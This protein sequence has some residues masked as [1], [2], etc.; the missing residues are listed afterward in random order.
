MAYKPEQ[1]RLARLAAFWALALLV[2]YGAAS[3]HSTLISYFEWA[4]RPLIAS[5]PKIP[6]LG[7]KLNAALLLSGLLLAGGLYALHWYLSKPKSADL[8]IET[9][10]EMRKVT[11]PSMTEAV[12][13]SVVV[14]V[15][16]LFLMAYLAGADWVL[17]FWTRQILLGE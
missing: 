8:L 10:S 2:F 5:L 12:N 7:L 11:W 16:V 13:S 6:V 1:G 17:G 15:C 9:E 14:I 4:G 3:F